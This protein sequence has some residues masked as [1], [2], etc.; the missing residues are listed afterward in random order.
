MR[1]LIALALLAPALAGAADPEISCD[2]DLGPQ[3]RDVRLLIMS[4][5]LRAVHMRTWEDNNAMGNKCNALARE[6]LQKLADVSREMIDKKILERNDPD[7][8]FEYC[9]RLE[10]IGKLTN[11]PDCK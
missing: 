5:N 1:R 8:L 10:E 11:R 3:P 2:S 9:S 4:R 7:L 6:I